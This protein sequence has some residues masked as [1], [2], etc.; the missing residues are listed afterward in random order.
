MGQLCECCNRNKKT[1]LSKK[2]E[3][4]DNKV[5]KTRFIGVQRKSD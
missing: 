4:G 3:L 2:K 1:L 5:G